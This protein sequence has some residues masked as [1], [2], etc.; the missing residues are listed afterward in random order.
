MSQESASEELLWQ[1]GEARLPRSWPS[2]GSPLQ[3]HLTPPRR[4][5]LAVASWHLALQ[6]WRQQNG[7]SHVEQEPVP[8]EDTRS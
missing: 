7:V 6:T 4:L 5:Y 3:G 2:Q 8:R 1:P